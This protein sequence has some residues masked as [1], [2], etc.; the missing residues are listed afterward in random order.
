MQIEYEEQ[1]SKYFLEKYF[2]IENSKHR[3][4]IYIIWLQLHTEFLVLEYLL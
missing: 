2:N 1:N 4:F 3:K